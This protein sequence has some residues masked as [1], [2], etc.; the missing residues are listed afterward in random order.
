MW[1]LRQ[2]WI[3]QKG[4]T[5]THHQEVIN[6]LSHQVQKEKATCSVRTGNK[7]G[8]KY[9]TVTVVQGSQQT[10]PETSRGNYVLHHPYRIYF[11]K[12]LGSEVAKC[13]M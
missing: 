1:L 12:G 3:L 5:K 9:S 7:A 10:P 13:K 4:S 8:H 11:L 2:L 6:K